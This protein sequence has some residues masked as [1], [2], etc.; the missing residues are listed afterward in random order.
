M[1]DSDTNRYCQSIYDALKD[2]QNFDD[3]SHTESKIREI[4]FIN[5]SLKKEY[6]YNIC[7]FIFYTILLVVFLKLFI[8]L[9]N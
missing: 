5:E 2:L 1:I 6:W 3:Y 9:E 7:E 8:F 4:E